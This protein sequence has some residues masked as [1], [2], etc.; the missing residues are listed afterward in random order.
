M[1][2]REIVKRLLLPHEFFA[3]GADD[4]HGDILHQILKIPPSPAFYGLGNAVKNLRDKSLVFNPEL[5]RFL[6]NMLQIL[7]IDTNV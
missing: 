4:F 2:L 3:P 1:G 7:A 5:F 6:L